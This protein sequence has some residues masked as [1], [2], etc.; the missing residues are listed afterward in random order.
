M[1]KKAEA[2]RVAKERA[3]KEAADRAERERQE[4]E[5]KDAQAAAQR[6]EDER[7]AAADTSSRAY[8]DWAKWVEIQKRMKAEVINPAKANREMRT[9]LKPAM[10]F[11]NRWIGQVVNT[12]EKIMEVVSSLE[13]ITVS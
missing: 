8:H 12:Q 10:R 1:A 11:I 9:A 7:K 13:R 2:E 4:K 3:E 5:A 6:E